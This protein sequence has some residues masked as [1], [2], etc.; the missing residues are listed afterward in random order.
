MT[1]YSKLDRLEQELIVEKLEQHKLAWYERM[2]KSAMAPEDCV[3]FAVAYR[4][5][6]VQFDLLKDMQS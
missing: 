5:W 3:C 1:Q 4:I 6:K 2:V